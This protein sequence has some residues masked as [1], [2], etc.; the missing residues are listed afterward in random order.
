MAHAF[1][2]AL[3]LTA[4][5][6]A[7]AILAGCAA[8][9]SS[10]YPR[11]GD[12]KPHAGVAM[13]H[14][15]PIH[16]IDISK[17]QGDVDWAAVRDAGTQFAFIKATEG[18]DHLDERFHTNWAGAKAAG[19]PRGFYHFMYWCRPAHEQMDW[20]K[21][22][23]PVEKDALPP[24]LDL[25]WNS[26]SRTCPIR[27]EAS[28][29]R[30]KIDYLLAEMERHFGKKPMIYTD[31]TFHRDV[32][33]GHYEGYRFWLRSVAAPPADRFNR[34]NFHFWQYTATGT[35]PGIRGS[36]DRNVFYGTQKQWAAFLGDAKEQNQESIATAYAE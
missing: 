4:I 21:Q 26:F 11:K 25:E 28:V 18:G 19:V 23:I 1:R 20:I 30:E 3:S 12:T 5:A 22:N 15:F 31:I 8:D 2:R 9:Y 29:A 14:S 16:G 34:S 32:L 10:R 33:E 13:A 7:A 6:A 24:V 35:V 27:L 36:V 17:Y